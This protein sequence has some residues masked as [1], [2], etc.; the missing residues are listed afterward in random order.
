MKT[1]IR[2]LQRKRDELLQQRQMILDKAIAEKR[3]YNAEEKKCVEELQAGV[4]AYDQ[5]IHD[6]EDIRNQRAGIPRDQPPVTMAI[7][8]PE[9]GTMRGE[10]E[11]KRIRFIDV[12]SGR[13]V[14]TFLPGEDWTRGRNYSL[15]D[16]IRPE[17][18]S[19]GRMVRGLISGDWTGAQAEQRT[20]AE[21]TGMLGGWMVPAPLSARIIQSARTKLRVM[22]AGALT[23]EMESPTLKMAK[24]I[25]E[26]TAHWVPENA[27]AV[28]SDLNFAPVEMQ[29]KK[30]VAM[31]K[32]SEEVVMDAGN[33][34]VLLTDSMGFASAKEIDR[35]ALLGSGTGEPLG[36]LNTDA[37]GM[38]DLD[39]GAADIDSFL[40][41]IFTLVGLNSEQVRIAAVYNADIAKAISKLKGTGSGLYLEPNAPDAWKN[42]KKYLTSQ[43]PTSSEQTDAYLGDYGDLLVGILQGLT[44]EISRSA[45]DNAGNSAFQKSQVWFRQT[46]RVDT[47]VVRPAS[48]HILRNVGV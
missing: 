16:G 34:D 1:D 48:F 7:G 3:G 36:L 2:L 25:S 6:A 40:D 42:L 39:G 5:Q 28:F 31:S 11:S 35:V 27:D 23:V 8:D 32:L 26:P 37:V 47:L 44:L 13:E 18:L 19:I 30:I 20:M 4:T 9:P 21:G 41:A 17:E 14:R 33:L 45:S 46:M 38:T 10:P 12:K 24:V 15:P 22:Q 29:A 43:I